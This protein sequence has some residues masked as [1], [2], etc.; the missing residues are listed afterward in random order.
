L[1]T[2][3]VDLKSAKKE[4]DAETVAESKRYRHSSC[5]CES[6]HDRQTIKW[7]CKRKF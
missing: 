1:K 5:V 6:T 7:F 2:K 4:L 3:E